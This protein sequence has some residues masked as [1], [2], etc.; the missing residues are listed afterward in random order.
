M[1]PAPLSL[2]PARRSLTGWAVLAVAM[3][4]GS[5]LTTL[6]LA[7]A[8]AFLP[9]LLI[10]AIGIGFQT[11][12]LMFCGL[13]MAAT[14]LWSLV[15]RRDIFTPPGVLLSPSDQPRLFRALEEVAGTLREPLPREVYLIPDV[16][17]WVAER[18]GTMGFGSRRVMG[19]GLSLMQIL[20]V[21]EFRAVL[22]HE[23]GHFYGGDTRM[24]PWVYKAR[25][26]MV[27]TLTH[28]G[29]PSALLDAVTSLV[30]A[31]LAYQ[32]VLATLVAYWK[33]FLRATQLV[34]RRME[35]RADEL[36][37]CLVGSEALIDGLRGIHGASGALPAFWQTEVVPLV[38]AGFHPP[39]AEGFGR[40][41]AAPGVA[42]AISENLEMQLGQAKTA[43]YDSHPPLR[44]R[45]AAARA[46]SGRGKMETD[47]PAITLLDG[48]EALELRLLEK[49]NPKL[50]TAALKLVRWEEVGSRVRLP[51]WKRWLGEYPTLLAGLTAES[52]PEAVR[53]R[54]E[55]GSRIRDP[56]GTLLT[57]EQRDQRACALLSIAFALA[58]MNNGW[59]LQTQPGQFCLQRGDQQLTPEEL[60][61]E[62][63]SGKL[64]TEAWATR[65]R[66]AGI[67][68]L[69]LDG[70]GQAAG[71]ESTPG[72][73]PAHPQA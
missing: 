66:D 28:L 41:V 29:S 68:G 20:S 44:E 46:L 42:K 27:R 16:N 3:V 37:C 65:C 69:R 15:P 6:L 47:P 23:F 55:L 43:P 58:V 39:I 31:R 35:F 73:R 54:R 53:N 62:M 24:G 12:V 2:V 17:A 51:I 50:K 32:L 19:L 13:V 59:E 60:I 63:K 57:R 30:L 70:S 21:S 48:V 26:A 61:E 52:L 71:A 49:L 40:F 56:K 4:I 10:G 72:E 33:L 67:A 38:E 64:T 36:A 18:G 22:A 14:I 7:A 5:Y 45:I 8:C 9:F 1:N 34:S 11:L 25:A